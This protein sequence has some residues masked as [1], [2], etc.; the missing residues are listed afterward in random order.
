MKELSMTKKRLM[1]DDSQWS[2]D[3]KIFKFKKIKF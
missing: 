3:C 2:Y 1:I